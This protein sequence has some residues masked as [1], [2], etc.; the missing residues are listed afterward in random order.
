MEAWYRT[1][2]ADI[3]PVQISETDDRVESPTGAMVKVVDKNHELTK[4]IPWETCP[5]FLGYNKLKLK[6]GSKLLATIGENND[7]LIVLSK[8]YDERVVVFA[9]DPVL[10]WGINFVNGNTTQSFGIEYLNGCV[11]SNLF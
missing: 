9:S 6:D 7:P 5:P 10:H 2:V 8:K 4:N 3:L 11:E 1:P